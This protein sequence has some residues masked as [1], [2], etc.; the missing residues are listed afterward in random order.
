MPGSLEDEH[1][2]TPKP[3]LY[4]AA[5]HRR[6]PGAPS[7]PSGVLDSQLPSADLPA[8]WEAQS[9]EIRMLI[10][11]AGSD[12]PV[13]WPCLS[14]ARMPSINTGA[15]VAPINN[16][17]TTTTVRDAKQILSGRGP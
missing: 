15:R 10:K 3:D 4:D 12:A 14:T 17:C 2:L 7:R 9:S 6:S 1:F 11:R 8:L 16:E 13:I 5:G